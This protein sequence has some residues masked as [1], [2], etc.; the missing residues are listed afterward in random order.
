MTNLSDDAVICP[1]RYMPYGQKPI[2]KIITA[3][4]NTI[5]KIKKAVS[6]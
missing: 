3:P 2:S 6:L 5:P 1:M 4:I